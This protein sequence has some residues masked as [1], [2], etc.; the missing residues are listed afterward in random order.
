ME[1]FRYYLLPTGSGSGLF[2]SGWGTGS[3]G[4]GWGGG[5][6]SLILKITTQQNTKLIYFV[7]P[8]CFFFDD[9]AIIFLE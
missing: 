3:P 1:N 4:F 2:E 6:G 9:H 5:F 8:F 7:F